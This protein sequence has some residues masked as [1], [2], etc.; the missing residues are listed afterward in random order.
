MDELRF[1][2]GDDA[3]TIIA[4][5][6]NCEVGSLAPDQAMIIGKQLYELGRSV[7]MPPGFPPPKP[8]PGPV[9]P[10]RQE[11]QPSRLMLRYKGTDG[12]ISERTVQLKM[13]EGTDAPG[14]RETVERL[15]VFCEMA[16]AP[17]TLSIS[18]VMW[19][20]HAE[21]GEVVPDLALHLR[22]LVQ[23]QG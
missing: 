11:V 3:T 13:V 12:K 8:L 10:W 23:G 14:K 4:F 16:N 7:L 15:N 2:L 18:G 19:A 17:R 6:G 9:F 1:V 20:A 21:T 5:L 22:L